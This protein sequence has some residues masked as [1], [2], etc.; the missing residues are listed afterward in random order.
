[1]TQDAVEAVARDEI[2]KGWSFVRTINHSRLTTELAQVTLKAAAQSAVDTLTSLGYLS[3][4]AVAGIE[5]AA[6]ESAADLAIRE[7][8]SHHITA[9]KE[10]MWE[11]AKRLG[12]E[13]EAILSILSRLEVAEARVRE[14]EIAL[15]P[16]VQDFKIRQLDQHENEADDT[17]W[18]SIFLVGDLRR[19]RDTLKD[20]DN[21]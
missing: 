7:F 17:T 4:S 5:R 6:M 11:A 9:N 3:P 1:M 10:A 2:I 16:F 21:G 15:K 13:A 19:A 14:L 20:K 18:S 12:L 8:D